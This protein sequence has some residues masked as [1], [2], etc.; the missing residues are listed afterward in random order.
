MNTLLDCYAKMNESSLLGVGICHTFSAKIRLL[1]SFL[2]IEFTFFHVNL[3]QFANIMDG[4]R[5]GES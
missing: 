2:E 5:K 3:K 4:K 1:F